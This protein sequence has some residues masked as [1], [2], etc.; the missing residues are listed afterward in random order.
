QVHLHPTPPDLPKI[1]RD[2]TITVDLDIVETIKED[3]AADVL[4]KFGRI[5]LLQKTLDIC[6]EA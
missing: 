2:P 6:E 4:V 1:G 5:K 3:T